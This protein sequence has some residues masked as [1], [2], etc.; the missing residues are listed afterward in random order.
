MWYDTFYRAYYEIKK[1][2]GRIFDTSRCCRKWFSISYT[3]RK[4]RNCEWPLKLLGK[5]ISTY[6][7]SWFSRI[8]QNVHLSNVH[9]RFEVIKIFHLFLYSI[10]IN[11]FKHLLWNKMW[12][13]TIR[14]LNL[15]WTMPKILKFQNHR[16][17]SWLCQSVGRTCRTYLST[18]KKKI[19]HKWSHIG[20]KYRQ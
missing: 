9:D 8:G 16:R 12:S 20:T 18:T 14:E 2:V 1:S 11:L 5:K 19:L 7:E 17:L 10:E 15:N 13:R 6:W 4:L 3:K